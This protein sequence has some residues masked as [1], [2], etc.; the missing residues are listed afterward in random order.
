MYKV[1]VSQLLSELKSCYQAKFQDVKL[2]FR[3]SN[4]TIMTI[5]TVEWKK[6][7]ARKIIWQKRKMWARKWKGR[8]FIYYEHCNTSNNVVKTGHS[9]VWLLHSCFVFGRPTG[10]S[11][12][13]VCCLALLHASIACLFFLKFLKFLLLSTTGF[14]CSTSA[15]ISSSCTIIIYSSARLPSHVS[16]QGF[17]DR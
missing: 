13:P 14:V 5:E 8:T 15:L 16:R 4:C 7:K 6:T 11:L 1:V 3:Y 10:L 9:W 2:L 17:A 12:K